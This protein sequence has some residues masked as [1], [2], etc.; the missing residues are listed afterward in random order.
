M[1]V[2]RSASGAGR[3]PAAR[4]RSRTNASMLVCSQGAVRAIVECGHRRDRPRLERP[5]RRDRGRQAEQEQAE[6][7]DLAMHGGTP[8]E[9]GERGGSVPTVST[10]GWLVHPQRIAQEAIALF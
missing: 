6:K 3:K 2:T 1:S 8:G 4:S 7:D 10:A 9:P 5:V